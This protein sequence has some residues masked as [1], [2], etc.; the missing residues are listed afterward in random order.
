MAPKHDTNHEHHNP[1]DPTSNKSV[2]SKLVTHEDESIPSVAMQDQDHTDT[3]PVFLGRQ[4]QFKIKH[5][6]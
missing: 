3:S 4:T 6:F 1:C 2:D 5:Q